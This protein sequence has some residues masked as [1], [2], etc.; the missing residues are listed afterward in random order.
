MNP[1]ILGGIADAAKGIVDGLMGGFDNLFTSKEEKAAK[2][3]ELEGIRANLQ[4]SVEARLL[5]YAKLNLEEAKAHLADT[6]NAREQNARIQESE[7]AS[8][9]SKNLAYILDAFIF[10]VWGSMT[11]YLIAS[12]LHFVKM[13]KGADVSGVLGVYSG[14]TAIAM[15][16]LN[17]H[18]GTSRGSEHKQKQIDKY[19]QK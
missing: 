13:E 11:I 14:V 2:A 10:A 16:V 15:T 19:F 7:K 12:M 6:A 17:F 1:A 9:L 5:E 8:W 4:N 18:R 3:N